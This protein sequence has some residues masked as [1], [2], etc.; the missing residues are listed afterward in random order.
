MV[1]VEGDDACKVDHGFDSSVGDGS[2]LLFVDG[3]VAHPVVFFLN[4]DGCAAFCGGFGQRPVVFGKGGGQRSPHAQSVFS[5]GLYSDCFAKMSAYQS[6][7]IV[8]KFHMLPPYVL[9][10]Y[11]RHLS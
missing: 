7:V 8:F 6:A 4:G 1:A 11:S 10:F 2:N 5:P 3:A 9:F